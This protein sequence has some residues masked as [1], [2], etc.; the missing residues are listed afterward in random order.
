MKKGSSVYAELPFC[1]VRIAVEMPVWLSTAFLS[2]GYTG[3]R[4]DV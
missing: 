1:F 4:V 3:H 2:L